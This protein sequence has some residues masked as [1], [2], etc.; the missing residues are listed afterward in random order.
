GGGDAVVAG[1][2]RDETLAVLQAVAGLEV[3]RLGLE[4]ASIVVEQAADQREPALAA[5]EHAAG[6]VVQVL[7]AGQCAASAV[8]QA[9]GVDAQQGLADQPAAA[10]VEAQGLGGRD[11][12]TLAVVEPAV[13]AQGHI[14]FAG[15]DAVSVIQARGSDLLPAKADQCALVAVVQG[16]FKVHVEAA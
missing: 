16:V 9:V 7:L 4:G 3:Q 10:I 12:A 5:I 14:G 2:G 13:D 6:A 1:Q 11:Q 8:V 15:D